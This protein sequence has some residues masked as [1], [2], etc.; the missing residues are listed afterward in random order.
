MNEEPLAACKQTQQQNGEYFYTTSFIS[1]LEDIQR[2][3]DIELLNA[4]AGWLLSYTNTRPPYETY[5]STGG[6]EVL[7]FDW[8]NCKKTQGHSS[9]AS[10]TAER[11]LKK[12]HWEQH[13]PLSHFGIKVSSLQMAR[14]TSWFNN[15][16]ML[17]QIE[18]PAVD[19]G[20]LTL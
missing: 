14:D 15:V 18:L 1:A 2:Q 13:I 10:L 16:P 5:S 8:K 4:T 9:A 6:S 12:L 17:T 7:H 19:F 3:R 20:V 11:D